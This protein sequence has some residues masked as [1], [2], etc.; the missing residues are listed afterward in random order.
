MCARSNCSVF[1]G[2]AD[3]M[4]LFTTGSGRRMPFRKYERI[5]RTP[6]AAWLELLAKRYLFRSEP[7]LTLHGGPTGSSMAA[8]KKFLINAFM[9]RPAITNCQVDANDESVMIDFLLAG[10]GLVAIQAIYALL[11]MSGHFIFVNNRVLQTR[12][13]LGALPGS[14]DEVGC[15]LSDLNAGTLA[16]DQ[17]RRQNQRKSN[18]DG[19]KH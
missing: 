16:V 1:V 18:N 12:V 17:K 9:A 3:C 4:A 10:R 6:C 15:R 2:L 5:R 8:A 13:A 11:R 7:L 19:Q 14:A